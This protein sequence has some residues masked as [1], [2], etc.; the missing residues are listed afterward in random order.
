MQTE[1]DAIV[2]NDIWYL[3][4]L[5]HGKKVIGNKWVYKLKWKLNGSI[6]RYKAMLVA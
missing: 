5:P 3:V 6:D 4:D 2:N 1:Y